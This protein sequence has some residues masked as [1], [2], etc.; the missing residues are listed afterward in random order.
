MNLSTA[1]SVAAVTMAIAATATIR[2]VHVTGPSELACHAMFT[3]H[4]PYN[5]NQKIVQEVRINEFTPW[6]SDPTNSKADPNPHPRVGQDVVVQCWYI[7]TLGFYQVTT[8]VE[9]FQTWIP[10]VVAP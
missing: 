7:D 9:G 2:G 6:Q 8:T 10:F 5:D 4:T 3:A 1:I